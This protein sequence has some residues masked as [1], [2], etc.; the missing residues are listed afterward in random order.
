MSLVYL[1]VKIKSLAAEARII[2]TEEQRFPR[3]WRNNPTYFG[4]RNHRTFDVRREAR[5][6]L[7]AYAYLRGRLYSS[8]EGGG[9][10]LPNT[11]RQRSLPDH[12][13]IV[14]LIYKFGNLG[15]VWLP[16][17]KRG[18]VATNVVLWITAGTKPIEFQYR[19]ISPPPVNT[20]VKAVKV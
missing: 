2:R 18:Q 11:E 1:R 5:A 16:V 8:V 19:E 9:E 6:A 17:E 12:L 14:Q 4:L 13:R 15:L 20:V 10:E 3:G 7:L